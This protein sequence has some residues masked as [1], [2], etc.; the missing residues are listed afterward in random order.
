MS[1]VED[2]VMQDAIADSLVAPIEQAPPESDSVADGSFDDGQLSPEAVES[3]AQSV[4]RPGEAL[5]QQAQEEWEQEREAQQQQEQ[6]EPPAQTPES[7]RE[8]LQSLDA[9]VEQ[10]QLNDPVTAKDFATGVCEA[11]GADA[12]VVDSQIF[13][14]T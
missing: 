12:R 10:Y 7:V 5:R 8:G 9:A 2:A 1:R 11:L 14:Q 4:A 6:N 13:G 3:L